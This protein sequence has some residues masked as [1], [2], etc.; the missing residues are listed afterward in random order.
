MPIG[1]LPPLPQHAVTQHPSGPPLSRPSISVSTYQAPPPTLMPQE[2]PQASIEMY[3]S[4]ASVEMYGSLEARSSLESRNDL[5]TG[6]PYAV[7]TG[8]DDPY[9]Q[10]QSIF[11]TASAPVRMGAAPKME[12]LG[13]G[14]EQEEPL[15]LASDD[16]SVNSRWNGDSGQGSIELR[17]ASVRAS[18]P[19]SDVRTTTSEFR[20][21]SGL[22]TQKRSGFNGHSSSANSKK[23]HHYAF[24]WLTLG[25]MTLVGGGLLVFALLHSANDGGSASADAGVQGKTRP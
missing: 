25:L 14:L 6:E 10:N 17:H 3:G 18:E 1:S 22:S 24:F 2:S 13:Q 12:P 5:Y 11:T 21:R 20:A 7:T 23:G 4:Q 19:S 8:Y 15:E 9:A 16:P